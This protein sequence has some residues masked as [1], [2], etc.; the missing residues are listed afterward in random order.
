[1]LLHGLRSFC[2]PMK[3]VIN[4]QFSFY[5]FN[6]LNIGRYNYNFNRF[7][8]IYGDSSLKE[9]RNARIIYDIGVV[10]DKEPDY[11][12]NLEKLRECE[13]QRERSYNPR[14]FSRAI[15]SCLQLQRFKLGISIIDFLLTRNVAANRDMINIFKLISEAYTHQAISFEKGKDMIEKLV[16]LI[17][18]LPPFISSQFNETAKL[19]LEKNIDDTLNNDQSAAVVIPEEKLF[20]TLLTHA[21]RRR[22]LDELRKLAL[23]YPSFSSYGTPLFDEWFKWV[24]EVPSQAAELV[25][26]FM[27]SMTMNYLELPTEFFHNFIDRYNKIPHLPSFKRV[28]LN[29]TRECTNCSSKFDPKPSFTDEEFDEFSKYVFEY[30]KRSQIHVKELARIELTYVPNMI[31]GTSYLG[32]I[33]LLKIFV[34]QL[35]ANFSAV[36]LI[37][38]FPLPPKIASEI[39]QLDKVF[40]FKTHTTSYDDDMMLLLIYTKCGKDTYYVTNDQFR[41]H[42]RRLDE[43]NCSIPKNRVNKI[44][45]VR[46]LQMNKTAGML[47]KPSEISPFVQKTSSGY[48]VPLR[49]TFVTAKESYDYYCCHKLF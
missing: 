23:R 42:L 48:H 14:D 38:K 18:N 5:L 10:D 47:E 24:E 35:L 41:D 43:S 26:I 17:Q 20:V 11:F 6:Q 33:K 40:Y 15:S 28:Q 34:E 21:I 12:V 9:H 25:Q 36:G 29:S 13:A 30:A 46:N 27:D 7:Y 4:A 8:V 1:M 2:R 45:G 31:Y 44:L 39:L 3:N 22:D 16:P 49:H 37:S 32:N 19:F